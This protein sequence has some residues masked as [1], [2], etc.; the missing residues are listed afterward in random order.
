MTYPPRNSE[1]IAEMVQSELGDLCLR[2]FG[3]NGQQSMWAIIAVQSLTSKNTMYGP[4]WWAAA[5]KP[6]GPCL[7]VPPV[8]G[9]TLQGLCENAGQTP[10]THPLAFVMAVPISWW[11][12][13][14]LFCLGLLTGAKTHVLST[15]LGI[16]VSAKTWLATLV[17]IALAPHGFPFLCVFSEIRRRERTLSSHSGVSPLS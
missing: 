7:P 9:C 10:M 14:L 5:G 16:V 15:V 6:Q 11:A 3:N 1:Q 12:F 13:K 4:L 2:S 17:E 8:Q